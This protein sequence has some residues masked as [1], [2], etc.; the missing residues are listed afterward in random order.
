MDPTPWWRS[1]VIYQVYPRSFAD[2]DGDGIGDLAGVRGKL[3]YLRDLGADAVWLS[4]FFTSP[5]V[6]GG[7]DVSD[8]RGVDPMF[9]TLGDFDALVRDAH[10]AGLRVIVDIVPNHSS[11]AHPWFVSALASPP[12]SAARDRY[13]FRPGR[14]SGSAPPNNWESI[15]GGPAWTRVPDGSWY[16]HLFDPTQPDLNW[17]NPQVRGEFSD[18][19][20]F[21]LDRGVDGFRVDVAHGMVK[22]AGLPDITRHRTGMLDTTAVPYFDQDDVHDIYREWR[23]ILD[24]Y[25][26]ERMAVA[27]AWVPNPARMSRYVRPDELHQAFNFDY[28]T[29][30]WSAPALRAAIDESIAAVALVG[31][32]PTWVLGN[33]D[34]VRPA[35][36]YGSLARA[37]AA[38]LLMLALP[39]SA[40]VYQ[41]EE[42]GL[43]QVTDL[44]DE[45]LQ[46]PVFRRS[47]GTVRGRDGCRV[48]IPWTGTEPPYGFSP[49]SS[50]PSWLPAPVGWGSLAVAAQSGVAGSTL[51]LYRSALRIRRAHPAL[52][53]GPGGSGEPDAPVGPGLRWLPAP[54][55]GVLAFVREPGFGC[56]ANLDPEVAVALPAHREVLL[57]SGPLADGGALPPDTS[58]WLAV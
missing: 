14:D 35:T 51:E 54:S 44:P 16:L 30:P 10:S 56:V 9:G 3:P 41:G 23:K 1:A 6:D 18:I 32:P 24:S 33:H 55:D 21:W 5:M 15:F 7:Y 26:G 27:E 37:R 43:P 13:I 2:S 11:S 20:R 47:G 31:A 29:A 19:L 48:P 38:A 46:D 36:R 22:A 52:G 17:D 40:Y 42:L 4:P 34:T 25:P 57:A 8:Y 49:P 45:V 28:L 39:G 50:A 53:A 58:A 12:G